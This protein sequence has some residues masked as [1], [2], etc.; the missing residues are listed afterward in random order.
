MGSDLGDPHP[1]Y[2]EVRAEHP[3]YVGDLM[4]DRLGM[5][6]TTLSYWPDGQPY[7]IVGHAEAL[8]V[9]RDNEHFSNSV[10]E[11]TVGKTHGRTVLVMD[12]PEHTF[13]R[14]ALR[15]IFSKKA[16]EHW[17]DELVVPDVQKR[18][19]GILERGRADLVRE[20]T[21]PF[22]VAIVHKILD[23]PDDKLEEFSSLAV[24]LLLYRTNPELA[25]TCGRHLG[26]ML[27]GQVD[28]ARRRGDNGSLLSALIDMKVDTDE[29]LDDDA[30]ISFLRILLPAGAETTTRTL[31]NLFTYLLSDP[32]LYRLIGEDRNLVGK[33]IDEALRIESPTQYVY[34]LCIEDTEVAGRTIPAG[35]PVAVSLS[36]ANRDPKVF[37]RPGEFRL[38]RRGGQIAFGNGV[39]VCLGMHLAMLEATTALNTALDKLPDLR[40][41]P[42]APEPVIGG[43]AFR[44]PG[45]LHVLAR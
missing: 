21:L 36:A 31:G 29:V 45:Y 19:D 6:A 8:R 12:A 27:Q 30:I 22:P 11:R 26:D 28:E 24:G 15:T 4:V 5:P 39:H 33:A 40:I 38:D 25:A 1:V 3:V 9:L 32:S 44:S 20:F 7:T 34:R 23:L 37:D 18:L 41:D 13:H 14:K 16:F 2:D 42:D 10:M 43:I 35:S 17:R